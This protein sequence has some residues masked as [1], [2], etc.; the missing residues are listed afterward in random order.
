MQESL[1]LSVRLFR[2]SARLSGDGL[3]AFALG[4]AEQPSRV[5]RERGTPTVAS[6]HFA[7]SCEVALKPPNG[8]RIHELRH[9]D[10]QISLSG[11]LHKFSDEKKATRHSTRATFLARPDLTQ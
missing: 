9:A 1:M 2:F 3:H 11:P 8:T 10:I 6:Q 5:P 4:L 7:D